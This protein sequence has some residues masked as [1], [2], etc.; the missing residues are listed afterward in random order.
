[1]NDDTEQPRPP[2][3]SV[4]LTAEDWR[5]VDR[6]LCDA[7]MLGKELRRIADTIH[8]QVCRIREGARA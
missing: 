8:V 6:V 4:Y 5:T 1:M 2:Q 7:P 3:Y